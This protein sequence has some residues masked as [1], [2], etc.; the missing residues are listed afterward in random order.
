M[1]AYRQYLDTATMARRLHGL[2]VKVRLIALTDE[3]HMWRACSAA[4]V[5]ALTLPVCYRPNPL[6]VFVAQRRHICDAF[7]TR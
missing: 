7:D 6:K 5:L 2:L 4:L 1:I 3:R